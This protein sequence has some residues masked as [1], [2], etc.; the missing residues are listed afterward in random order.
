MAPHIEP[1]P[2]SNFVSKKSA[3]E[4]TSIVRRFDSII[5]SKK[6]FD[7]VFQ[8]RR[9]TRTFCSESLELALDFVQHVFKPHHT[10][11]RTLSNRQRKAMVSGGALHPIDIIVVSGNGVNEPILFCDQ[12]QEFLTLPIE[13]QFSFNAAVSEARKIVPTA[14]GHMLL[15][16]G[17]L[18]RVASAYDAPESLLW[19]DGGAAIQT[20]SMAAHAYDLS[21]CPLGHTGQ[22]ILKEL[23]TPHS[24]MIA[25]GLVIIGSL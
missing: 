19:R 13:N 22:A 17:D 21:C 24:D 2:K 8:N 1:K 16:V 4:A 3:W 7:E 9:T 12:T 6:S 5:S 18:H 14:N 20:C 15:F 11:K 23:R 10:G 25:I